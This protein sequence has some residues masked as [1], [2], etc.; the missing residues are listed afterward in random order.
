MNYVVNPTVKVKTCEQKYT[1]RKLLY[2][3]CISLL[4]AWLVM[5]E[6][7]QL[8]VSIGRRSSRNEHGITLFTIVSSPSL[9]TGARVVDL[10]VHTGCVVQAPMLDA[11]VSN[12][13][14]TINTC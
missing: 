9:F 3:I 10:M 6:L 1:E 4:R 8:M 7:H 14:T 5:N 11:E 13:T 2:V 12:Y